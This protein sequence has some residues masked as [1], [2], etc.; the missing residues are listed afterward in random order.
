MVYKLKVSLG[1]QKAQ[2]IVK[3]RK[4]KQKL[5]AGKRTAE[6]GTARSD[7]ESH[8]NLLQMTL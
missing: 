7:P 8:R 2:L 1:Q 3:K 5:R 6:G 4:E